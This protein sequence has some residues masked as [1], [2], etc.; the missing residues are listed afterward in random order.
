MSDRPLDLVT[1]WP[2]PNVAAAIHRRGSVLESVG[3]TARPFRLASIGKTLV[4]WSYLVGVEEGIVGLDDIVGPDDGHVRT[5]RHLL[6]HAGGHGFDEGD[7]IVAP[8]RTRRYGNHG[9]EVAAAHL[10]H[11]A[12]M[13]YGEYLRLG[14]LE[15]L[16]MTSTDVRGSPAT[17]TWSS[18]DD[19]VLFCAEVARPRLVTEATGALAVRPHFP[20]LGGIVPGVGRFDNCPWG[21][22]FE[23]RGDKSPHWTGVRNSVATYGHFGGAGTMMWTDPAHDDLGVVALTDLPFDEWAAEAL[24]VW[25]AL[26]DAAIERFGDGAS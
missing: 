2:V 6:S 3:P 20:S 10:A 21:L 18:V 12:E 15:P 1:V 11:A 16:G 25:P 24:Q 22:G 7:P 23:V 5:V 4:A 9:I 19:L 8:E 13:P 14:V 17:H 26:S